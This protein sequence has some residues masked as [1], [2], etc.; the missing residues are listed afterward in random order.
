MACL[1]EC[2]LRTEAPIFGLLGRPEFRPT[3]WASILPE[4]PD[5]T[6]CQLPSRPPL[7]SQT[8]CLTSVATGAIAPRATNYLGS[9][10]QPCLVFSRRAPGF[11]CL[12]S[13][14]CLR[15]DK[16]T[17][18]ASTAQTEAEVDVDDYA[19]YLAQGLRFTC[20]WR[21]FPLSLP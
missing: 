15:R 7:F 10:S 9:C 2:R 18:L 16:S 14:E 3:L 11:T 17:K 13:R 12:C 21:S 20:F 4:L 5:T 8:M 19:L 6:R 1:G